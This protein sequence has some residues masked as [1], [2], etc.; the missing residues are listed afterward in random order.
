M[1]NRKKNEK[2]LKDYYGILGI[3]P[4]ASQRAIQ[5]AFRKR[6][7]KCHPDINQDDP[8]ATKNFKEL[9]E[10]YQALKI[11][12]KRNEFDSRIISEYCMSFLGSMKSE[13]K[14]KV[15]RQSEFLRILKGRPK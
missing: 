5:K 9:A 3:A 4:S 1:K 2:E 13:E 11:K 7:Q 8:E 6:A 14:T 15:K 10:A 12:E